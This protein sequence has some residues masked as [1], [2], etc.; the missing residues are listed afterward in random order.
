MP[1]EDNNGLCVSLE[2]LANGKGNTEGQRVPGGSGTC[3][4]GWI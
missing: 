1:T 2:E 3:P 4:F